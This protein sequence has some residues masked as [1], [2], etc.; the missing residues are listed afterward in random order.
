MKKKIL[1]ITVCAAMG[2]LLCACGKTNPTGNNNLTGTPTGTTELTPQPTP[3]LSP[4]EEKYLAMPVTDYEEY[5]ATTVLPEGYLDLEVDAIT[6][7]DVDAYVQ[8]TLAANKNRVVKD[9][10]LEIGDIV[11]IDYYGYI[12]GVMQDEASDYSQEIELG[13]S[14]YIDG[15]DEGLVGAKKGDTVVLNLKFPDNY[16]EK[17]KAGNDVTF[18]VTILSSAAQVLPEFTD[19]FVTEVTE[20]TCTTTEDYRLYAKGFLQEEVRY[21]TV[22]DYLVENATFGKMNED[23]IAASLA[24]EK[25]YYAA[26]YGCTSVA[27]FEEIFGAEESVIMWAMAEKR[28]RRY[29]QDRIALYCVAK[30]ENLEMTEDE[31]IARVTDYAMSM[32]VTY[33]DVVA[34]EGESAL[35][36]SMM[37]EFA[38]ELLLEETTVVTKEAE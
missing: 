29:E 36:Q 10:A 30:A 13:N 37:M 15:F 26:M 4:L 24:F 18:E 7:A 19:E 16:W 1:T 8:E 27:E 22:M 2:I 5:V 20:G 33:A 14:G 17:E 31:F 3:T 21:N 25:E 35:R 11:I 32:G 34:T 38:M 23:Y 9:T 28:I 12:D 6:E